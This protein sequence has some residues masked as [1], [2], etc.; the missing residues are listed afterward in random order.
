MA[1]GD[2]ENDAPMVAAAGWGVAVANAKE[3]VRRVAAAVTEND[4]END[5]V[6]EAVE[7]WVLGAPTPPL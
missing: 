5:A 6:A 7:R 4:C 1:V 3:A 2:N